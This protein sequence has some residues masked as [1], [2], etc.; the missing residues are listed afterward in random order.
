MI[1]DGSGDNTEQ[2]VQPYLKKSNVQYIK[3]QNA[4]VC[5]TR[6]R[7]IDLAQGDYCLFLDA[8][9]FLLEDALKR[10]NAYLELHPDTD[11]LFGGQ[12]TQT[13][14]GK[15]KQRLAKTLSSKP[16]TNF[17]DL[18]QGKLRIPNGSVVMFRIIP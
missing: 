2:V 7:G 16:E 18:T 12:I 3:Q 5:A 10:F 13:A 6:N 17:I 14:D 9:D 15:Q 1:D 4:G 11:L 8:D